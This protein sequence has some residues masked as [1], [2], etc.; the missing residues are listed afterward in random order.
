MTEP[1]AYLKKPLGGENGY[2]RLVRLLGRAFYAGEC[3]PR[4]EPAK[5][6]SEM[7]EAQRAKAAKANT[8]GL[9]VLLLDVLTEVQALRYLEAEGLLASENVKKA[10]KR[11]MVEAVDDPEVE[12]RKRHETHVYWCIAYPALVDSLRLRL[13]RARA[14]LKKRAEDAGVGELCCS[15][16][17]A[18]GA[19]RR[20]AGQSR[21]WKFRAPAA[22]PSAVAE[23]VC[24]RC[25]ATATSLDAAR[26]LDPVTLTFRCEECKIGELKERVE[27]VP[28]GAPPGERQLSWREAQAAFKTLRSQFEAQLAPLWEQL[29][30]LKDVDPPD[31]GSLREW[32][33]AQ[34]ERERRK[35]ARVEA[36]R[37]RARAGGVE[38]AEEM[39]DAALLEWADRAEVQ[40]NFGDEAGTAGPGAPAAP[41]KELPAWF[42]APAAGGGGAAAEDAAAAAAA[43][44]DAEAQRERL[45]REYLRAYLAQQ[46]AALASG[47]PAGAASAGGAGDGGREAKRLKTENGWGAAKAEAAEQQGVKEE[48]EEGLGWEDVKE[49]GAA[50]EEAAAAGQQGQAAAGAAE[51]DVEFEDF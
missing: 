15:A 45:S 35:Q 21:E 34:K 27:G 49:E 13:H 18:A 33:L 20:L 26:L 40:V 39:D 38:G 7:T 44:A 28:G 9:G 19:A 50:K 42:R 16:R 47:A 2:K 6:E 3:P 32:A 12:E 37:A 8:E 24:P 25:G 22:A 17:A 4:E 30:R 51:E 10:F 1:S 14:L 23:Y 11:T 5:P 29:E 31:Y 43:A 36:A 41:G 48:Q 46:Q